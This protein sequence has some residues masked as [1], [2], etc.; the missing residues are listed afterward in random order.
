LF[1]EPERLAVTDIGEIGMP[2]ARSAAIASF[3]RAI[4][5]RGLELDASNRQTW[6]A[7][8]EIP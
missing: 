7:L 2:R 1:P 3:A 8:L 5:D 6:D 4:A